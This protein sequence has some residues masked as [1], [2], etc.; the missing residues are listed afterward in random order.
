VLLPLLA[1]AALAVGLLRLL[2]AV[3]Y[4]NDRADVA[5]GA[6]C[7]LQARVRKLEREAKRTPCEPGREGG[8]PWHCS[9]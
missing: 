2:A 3:L 9:E 7:R 4:L 6:V 8:I 5:W 1:S